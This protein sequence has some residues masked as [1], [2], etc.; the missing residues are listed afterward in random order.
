MREGSSPFEGSSDGDK[1]Q[2]LRPRSG[3][4]IPVEQLERIIAR[5]S[6]LQQASGDGEQRRL[7]EDDVI[8]IGEEVGLAPEHVRRALTEYRTDA[9]VPALPDE[10]PLLTRWVGPAFTRV[11]RAIH[12]DASD[13]HREFEYRLEQRESMRPVRRRSTES[14]WEPN[15]GIASS[16][17]RALDLEG[18]GYEL[19]QLGSLSVVAVPT[20]QDQS[21]VTVT[22]DLTAAR[23]DLLSNWSMSIMLPL[24]ILGMMALTSQPLWLLLWVPAAIAG[25]AGVGYGVSWS[26]RGK[27]RRAALL[28][29]GLLDQLELG[30]RR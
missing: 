21:L 20:D 19:T 14:V 10:H 9:L 3:V 1:V 6:A 25:L 16:I 11:R 2:S 27:R 26:M 13:V 22:A 15:K 24:T 18:R 4:Q 5:A 29:E 30:F 12:G 23:K 7:S 17:E 28:L 8:S